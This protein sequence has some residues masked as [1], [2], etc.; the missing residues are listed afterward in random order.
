VTQD[1]ITPPGREP[2]VR[3]WS[4]TCEELIVTGPLSGVRVVELGGIGPAPHAG[5]VLAD[6][7]AD[8]VRI[9]RPAGGLQSGTPDED[10]MLRGRRS[11]AAD[12]KT[13]D[14]VDLVLRLTSRADVLLE[15]FRPGVAERLGV[16]PAECLRRRPRLI[17]ARMTGWG[18]DGPWAR[19]VGH[20]INYLSVAGT[21]HAL[22]RAGGPPE[23]P[24]NL[25]GDYAG[26]SMFVLVGIL[27][28]LVERDRSGLGQVVDAAMV[29]GVA[30]LSQ[31]LWSL[32]AQG[33]WTEQ[34]G[35]NLLDGGAP[36]YGVYECADGGYV[37]VGALEPQF[38]RALLDGLELVPE[39]L[40]DRLDRS[41]WP[42]L[43]EIFAAAFARQ[44]RDH[45]D[46]LFDGTD[47]CVTPVLTPEEAARHPH[48]AARATLVEIDGVVQAA[49]APRF[50]RTPGGTAGLTTRGCDGDDVWR[51]WSMRGP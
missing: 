27:A 50:S 19:R 14:G 7:G 12:L 51:D 10:V 42:R 28:A 31:L 33:E 15:G 22:G 36:F 49:P 38:Y 23:P 43:R 41:G 18:Q 11:V 5:M 2:I 32:R 29:D 40:P 44:P 34:R 9:V 35:T 1:R 24:I 46:A 20:D 21:L 37:A 8:V 39:E 3:R 26:G 30:A 25:L 16:G 4:P 47:A 13:P 48:I 45:W 6:L 17:Y